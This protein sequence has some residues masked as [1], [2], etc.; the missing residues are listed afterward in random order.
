MSDAHV[1]ESRKAPKKPSNIHRFNCLSIRL[2]APTLQL[3]L[4]YQCCR[5]W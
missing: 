3:L 2:L 1:T 4:G 5:E